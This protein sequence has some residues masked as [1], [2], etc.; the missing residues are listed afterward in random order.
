MPANLQLLCEPDLP[1]GEVDL[2]ALAFS[3]KGEAEL[4]RDLLQAAHERL[5]LGGR[6]AA[7]IDN[8][9]DQWLHEQLRGMFDKVTRRPQHDS[10]L[11]LATKTKPLKKHKEFACE[12]SFRDG[13]RLIQLRTRPGVFSH[14]EVDD[15]ARALIK[16]MEIEPGLRVLD[17]GCGSGAV[18]IAAALR[19][20][21]VQVQALDSNPR[22]IEA[23][24]WAAQKNGASTLT[25]TL[26]CDG[27]TAAPASFDLVLANPPYFSNFRIAALFLT[28]A[29]RAL[30]PGGK[31]LLV[32][33]TP[34]W[35]ATNLPRLLQT[36]GDVIAR[37]VGKFVVIEATT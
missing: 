35:Y 32:T 20:E 26:D 18:G 29:H 10:V 3:K 12:L 8:S 37:P 36:T 13:E 27:R 4:V 19:A 7:A 9:G 2:A 16:S 25:A 15:G 21:G 33:K 28:I 31:L 1:P 34:D 24:Q 11:Y 6:M 23:S 30:A 5:A 17:L 14:R 22:A